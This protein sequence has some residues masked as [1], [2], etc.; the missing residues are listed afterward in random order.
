MNSQERITPLMRQYNEFKA[1]YPDSILLFRVGD[2]YET[3]G[4]DAID[5]SKILNIVLTSRNKNNQDRLAGFPYHALETYLPRLIQ[6]GKR[7]AICEQIEDPKLAKG[8]VKRNV[9]EV[10]TPGISYQGDGQKENSFLCAIHKEKD[11]YGIAFIDI[12]TGD[13]FVSEGK[14]SDMDKLLQNF[15]PKEIV[16][17]RQKEREYQNILP[18]NILTKTYDDWVFSWDFAKGVLEDTFGV[19]SVKGF[20]IN[21]MPLS[22]IAAGSALYYI[23]ETNHKELSH[24]CNIARIDNNDFVWMDKFTIKNLELVQS[25]NSEQS[26]LYYILNKT[27]TNMGARLLQRW[28][29]LPLKDKENIEKRQKVV[30]SLIYNDDL[31]E[32]IQKDLQEIGDMER[33]IS[34]LSVHKITPL[35]LYH[36]TDILTSIQNIKNNIALSKDKD[37][38]PILEECL[39]MKD[40]IKRSINSEAPNNVNKGNVIKQGYNEE[41]DKYRDIIYNS[42]TIL[43]KICA[44]QTDITNIPSLKIGFNNV[45]GYYLEVTNTHKDKVP[46][47]WERKQTLTNAERYIIPELKK[48]EGQIINAQENISALE[49]RLYHEVI[50][51]CKTYM[52]QLHKSAR[53]LAKLDVLLSFALVTLENNY[54]KP[55]LVENDILYISMG[56]HPVIEK[57]LP[58]GEEYIANDVYLDTTTQQIMIITG[59]NMSGKSA[60]L[61]QTALIVIMAQMGCYVPA[62][63]AKIGM[64]DKIFTR[65]G[66]SD[67]IASGESTFMV[68]MNE[69]A[70]ILNNLSSHSLVLLDEIGRG[71]STYDGVSIA[72]GIASF[73]HEN[74]YRAK[75]LFATHYH[76]L[77]V[78]EKNFE[79]IKN[80]HI[81][82]K[83][84][85]SKILFIRKI[86]QG[87]SSQSFGIH[88][89]R[90]AGMPK[91]VLEIANDMLSRLEKDRSKSLQLD[92]RQADKS[93]K[94][95]SKEKAIE[96]TN[97]FNGFQTSF[98]QLNDPVLEQVKAEIVNVDIENLTPIQALNKLNEIKNILQKNKKR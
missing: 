60:Y 52:E 82:V 22:A 25:T 30:T 93:A 32:S 49:T 96:S 75:V 13:F 98:I 91:Q 66:A 1:K 18:K 8:I 97:S 94:N 37:L 79:R 14:E 57:L 53:E 20:G 9:E 90:L 76:E 23:K 24:I 68:E 7:V 10:I 33:I 70:S 4:Q 51:E 12:N 29:V 64:V 34:R 50:E 40:Y 3:F 41:L 86:A 61:R 16:L 21:H 31:R 43:D 15:T 36:F 81:T 72:W 92:I 44:Q 83:E 35:E 62:K 42:Q 6:A 2:F 38:Y 87:G 71:T 65:V 48:M 78:M 73:L 46:S 85:G 26:T 77:I 80:Y 27:Q 19:N 56:R 74:K 89:A 45:F 54:T 47:Y 5:T 88:V 67:N 59:P 55:D 11:E 17:Q 95:T 39:S 84:V 63:R 58:Q 28:I 69:T